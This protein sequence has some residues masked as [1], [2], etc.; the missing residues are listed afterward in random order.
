M[1]EALAKYKE[2]KAE[3]AAPPAKKVLDLQLNEL[4]LN[5]LMQDEARGARARQGGASRRGR[6]NGG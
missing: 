6:V 4:G 3:L 5:Y 2:V 1:A